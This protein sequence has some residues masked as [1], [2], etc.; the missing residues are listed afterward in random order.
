[1]L[2][3]FFQL[4][5]TSFRNIQL[6]GDFETHLINAH[7][8]L[9]AK[10]IPLELKRESHHP[11]PKLRFKNKTF[12]NF[13]FSKTL[14]E[15]VE[16]YDCIF[17][18]CHFI[19]VHIKNCLFQNCTFE[20]V[21]T[22]KIIIENTY[23]NPRSM[24][25]SVAGIK[26]ANIGVHLFQQLLHN[27]EQMG[28]PTFAREAEFHFNKWENKLILAKFWIGLPSKINWVTFL[29]SYPH[30]WVFQWMFGF[31]LRF[32]NFVLSFLFSFIVFWGVNYNNWEDY[33]M[34]PKDMTI[35]SF[36]SDSTRITSSAFYTLDVTTKLVDSQMQPKSNPGMVWL[37]IQS[38]CAFMLM[39]ALITLILNRFVK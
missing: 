30:R 14:I 33:E 27:S 10:Y 32:R 37:A 3:N 26:N 16:F 4:N 7:G 8:Y 34:A 22:F 2:S 31:G 29:K 9:N 36:E 20:S 23:L 18:D 38:I 1:M 25:K 6:Q 12:E 39:S 19:G 5:G 15:D 24:V 35:S 17:K 28:Q 11:H 21:N 13:S